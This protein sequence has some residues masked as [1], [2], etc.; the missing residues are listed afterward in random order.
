MS[1]MLDSA[2]EAITST[3]RDGSSIAV[4]GFGL[5]GTPDGLLSALLESGARDLHIVTNNCGPDT[6]GMT[7]LLREGRVRRIT[8]SYIGANTTF[9]KQYID[10]KIAVELVPQGT[11]AEKLRSGGAGIPGF[12]TPTG[13]GT[14]IADGGLPVRYGPG[15]KVIEFSVPREVRSFNGKMCV[16]EES[17]TVD[18]ALLRAESADSEGN[19]RFHASA[20]NFN[21]LCAMAG[22]SAIVEV[23]H[24]VV[25][26]ALDPDD[27][28]LPG[29]FITNVIPG[30]LNKPIERRRIADRRDVI[31]AS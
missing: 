16:L 6:S 18:V 15:G 21:P 24:G 31:G 2:L 29:I 20:R 19:L 22:R 1:K 30:T 12:Y 26:G 13:V 23:E 9:L 8:A 11:L 14:V 4:G 3:V 7:A 25:L 17:I 5:C 27:I 28:H 10:G